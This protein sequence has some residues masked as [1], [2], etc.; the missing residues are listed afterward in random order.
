MNG[1]RWIAFFV[2]CILGSVIGLLVGMLTAQVV[3]GPIPLS[4]LPYPS[5]Y[6]PYPMVGFV[7]AGLVFYAMHL[8]RSWN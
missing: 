8:V 3:T 6:W 1:F 2:T 4:L 7:I 5:L